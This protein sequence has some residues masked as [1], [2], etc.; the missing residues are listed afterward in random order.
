M[1]EAKH[2]TPPFFLLDKLSPLSWGFGLGDTIRHTRFGNSRMKS[3]LQTFFRQI[4]L[5]TIQL[6]DFQ[7]EIDF[8]SQFHSNRFDS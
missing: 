2:T 4:M 6:C 1:K 3:L 5:I 7:L 8:P